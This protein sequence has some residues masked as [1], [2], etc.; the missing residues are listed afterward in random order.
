MRSNIKLSISLKFIKTDM[1]NTFHKKESKK[2]QNIKLLKDKLFT[3]LN[4]KQFR[5][6]NLSNTLNNQFNMYNNQFKPSNM[7][8]NPSNMYNNN[9][10]NMYNNNQCNMFNNNLCNIPMYHS[11]WYNNPQP[12]PMFTVNPLGNPLPIN[13]NNL[14][15]KLLPKNPLNKM[16]TIKDFWKSSSID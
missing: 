13:N 5:K 7:F 16:M 4:R 8:N 12:N 2:E 11:Q 3:N 6:S 9:P 15:A 10:S 1:S 14:W